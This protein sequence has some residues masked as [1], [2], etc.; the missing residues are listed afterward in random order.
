MGA[1]FAILP[2]ASSLLRFSTAIAATP[3]TVVATVHRVSH[4]DTITTITSEGTQLC[5]RRLGID[6]PEMPHGKKPGQPIGEDAREYVDHLIGG[7]TV[8][9]ATKRRD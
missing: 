1:A 4:G 6:P 8:Q 2:L 7:K 9:H 3:R 5:I